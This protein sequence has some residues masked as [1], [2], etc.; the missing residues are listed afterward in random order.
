MVD[1]HL[2]EDDARKVPYADYTVDLSKR[3]PVADINVHGV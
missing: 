2:G 3:V 1:K